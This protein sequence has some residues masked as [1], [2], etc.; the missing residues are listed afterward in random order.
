MDKRMEEREKN[1]QEAI[2]QKKET[3][4]SVHANKDA[5]AE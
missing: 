2:T 1:L 3:I 5:A 4:A